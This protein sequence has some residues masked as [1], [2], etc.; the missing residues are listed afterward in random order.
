MDSINDIK[1]L[2]HDIKKLSKLQKEITK[3]IRGKYRPELK[4]ISPYVIPS[5]KMQKEFNDVIIALN[6]IQTY[7]KLSNIELVNKGYIVVKESDYIQ[8]LEF[9]RNALLC[10]NKAMQ[11]VIERKTKIN[12][13]LRKIIYDLNCENNLLNKEIKNW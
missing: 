5:T 13:E 6:H 3:Y 11:L 2:V 7:F 9:E 8:D 12:D 4:L 10:G 1:R